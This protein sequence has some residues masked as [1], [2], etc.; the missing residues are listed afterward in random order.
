MLVLKERL[1]AAARAID[2]KAGETLFRQGDAARG[3]YLLETGRVRLVRHTPDGHQVPLHTVQPGESFAEASLFAREYHCDCVCLATA[4]VILLPARQVIG[5]LREGDDAAL[6]LVARLASHVRDLRARA[7]LRAIRDVRLRL[8][9]A[10]RM[11]M[12]ETGRVRLQ[13]SLKALAAELGMAHETLYRTL[14][15]LQRDGHLSR[16]DG[17]ITIHQQ[18]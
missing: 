15:A 14:A 3:L 12:D 4:R 13:G 11:R 1:G 2:L 16:D 8:L 9:A 18:N 10:L 5:L 7:E 17:V 6:A